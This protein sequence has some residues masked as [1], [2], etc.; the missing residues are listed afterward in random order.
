MYHS[1]FPPNQDGHSGNHFSYPPMGYVPYGYFQNPYGSS[2]QTHQPPYGSSDQTHQPPYASSQAHQPPYASSQAHPVD[3]RFP[4][5]Q[6]SYYQQPP[7]VAVALGPVEQSPRVVVK[8]ELVPVTLEQR[9]KTISFLK[10]IGC[11][12][13]GKSW[14]QNSKKI[15][16]QKLV[17][18]LVQ[19]KEL[20]GDARQFDFLLRS[21]YVR[22]QMSI[23][24]DNVVPVS[25]N[26]NSGVAE[27]AAEVHASAVEVHASAVEVHASVPA[28][29]A[30]TTEVN[31]E[32]EIS[33][34]SD[35]KKRRIDEVDN[36]VVKPPLKA[37]Y[38]VLQQTAPFDQN[39][40]KSLLLQTCHIHNNDGTIHLV[41]IEA[42]IELYK[43]QYDKKQSI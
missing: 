12:N 42:L 20:Q 21:P 15:L 22:A 40:S 23:K 30:S 6:R 35:S 34:I 18:I 28:V 1:G 7:N 3:N 4:L 16:I 32:S 37:F 10:S 43:T 17:D 13:N 8:S 9:D 24:K 14:N 31:E 36:I 41:S 25:T 5:Y 39:S 11:S 2:D 19:Q 38:K 26:S 33:L 29:Q 27:V